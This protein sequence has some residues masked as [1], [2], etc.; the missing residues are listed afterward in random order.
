[1]K[2]RFRTDWRA[3]K[4]GF[5]TVELM[6]ATSVS[7]VVMGG[8]FVVFVFGVRTAYR[9]NQASWGQ[10]EIRGASEKL[11]AYMRNAVQI[12]DVDDA[13]R[14]VELLMPNMTTSRFEYVNAAG[15]AGM[16][17]MVFLRDISV[18]NA[19]TNIVARGLTEVMTTP[20]RNI[21]HKTAPN[22]L[23]VAFRVTKPYSPGELPTEID[24]GVYL[25]NYTPSISEAA[26]GGEMQEN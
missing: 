7:V 13:G 20:P 4:H 26:A 22:A 1:M 15:S 19:V 18:T 3:R 14:W 8:L 6:I 5:T 11:V 9:A 16:G 2:T 12:T 24:Y 25:R 10:T 21:F 23:R 17:K